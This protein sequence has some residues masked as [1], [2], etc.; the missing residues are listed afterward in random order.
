[1]SGMYHVPVLAKESIEG[2]RVLPGGTYLDCTLG[3]GG[4]FEAIIR[5]LA[6]K[7]TVLGIDQDPD[8]VSWVRTNVTLSSV[9]TIIEQSPFSRL[10]SVLDRHGIRSVDG[11]VL[12]LGVSSHQI[13]APQRGFSY[14][15][16]TVLDMRMDPA[17][18][19]PAYE[20]LRDEPQE[21]LRRILHDYGEIRDAG[22]MARVI[23]EYLRS[24]ELRT[25]GQLKQCL[26]AHYGSVS[27]KLLAKTF[28]ALRIA[29]NGEMEELTACLQKAV[30]RLSK[31]GR[32]VAISYH[33]LEDRIVKNF[34]QVKE[35]GC[36]CPADSPICTCR[37]VSILKR[38]TKKAIRPSHDE[39]E[40]NHR[41][42]S[43]RLR[44][45]EKMV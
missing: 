40:R 6:G 21:E 3:G 7:G 24:R 28:Q 4:H 15:H 9:R 31:G 32:L 30:D 37:N 1:M 16:D 22:R 45:A 11:V 10:D 26:A 17:E 5:A 25:S 41:A 44:V 13:D 27:V 19:R 12:D 18:G 39:I 43:A 38:I 35:K 20:L 29:V 14:M 36:T 8:S 34:M 42:R 2:L 23:K 33:S